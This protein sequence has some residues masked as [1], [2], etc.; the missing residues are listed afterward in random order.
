MEI[1]TVNEN[2]ELIN[3]LGNYPNLEVLK[4]HCLE[5]LQVLP[6]AIGTLSKLKELNMDEGNGCAMNPSFPKPLGI[7]GRWKN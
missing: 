6:D 2:E 4:I 5:D 3:E 7:C 1:Y